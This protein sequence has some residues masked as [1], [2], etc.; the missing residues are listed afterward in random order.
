[1]AEWEYK[2]YSEHAYKH[3]YIV[4]VVTIP[5]ISEDLAA[6]RSHHKLS[7]QKIESMQAIWEPLE[8]NHLKQKSKEL[9]SKKKSGVDL[10][11]QVSADQSIKEVDEGD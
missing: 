4:S 3:N 2:K 11:A 8:H 7:K 9:A 5:H 1:M 10:A 6:K